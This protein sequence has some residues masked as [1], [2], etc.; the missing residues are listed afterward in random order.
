MLMRL[1][2]TL[3]LTSPNSSPVSFAELSSMQEW[4]KEGVSFI[5]ACLDPVSGKRVMGGTGN[6]KFSPNS[7][8]TR[9]QS[10]M[11]SVRLFNLLRKS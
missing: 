2:K 11:T 10:I 5:S 6:N 7:N 1:A 9:E 4:A 3:G 8:Y